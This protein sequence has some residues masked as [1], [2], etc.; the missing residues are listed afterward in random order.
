LTKKKDKYLFLFFTGSCIETSNTTFDCLCTPGWEGIHCEIMVDYCQN[1][2]CQNEGICCPS[3]LNYTCKCLHEIYSG[4]H[5]EIIM[6][7]SLL[8]NSSTANTKQ[9][10]IVFL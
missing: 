7:E 8:I 4:R 9:S 2:T 5:C 1:I 6:N 3:V 10:K